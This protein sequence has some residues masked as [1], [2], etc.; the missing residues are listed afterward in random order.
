MSEITSVKYDRTGGLATKI[1]TAIKERAKN[2]QINFEEIDAIIAMN[3]RGEACIDYPTTVVKIKS[4]YDFD[5]YWM[6]QTAFK[7]G[8]ARGHKSK[9]A[10]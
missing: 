3:V 6:I 7:Y 5:I 4:D 10:E 2:A 1:K 8:Y 9:K